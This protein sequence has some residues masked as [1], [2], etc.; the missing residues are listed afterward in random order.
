MSI[1]WF[2]VLGAGLIP[3]ILGFVWYH[4]KVFG[5]A[6]MKEASVSM[7]N[8]KQ[9]NM[10]LIFG[11]TLLFGIFLSMAMLTITIHQMHMMST[12]MNVPG[13]GKEGTEVNNYYMD[14]LAK[15][16]KEFRTFKH[17]ALHGLIGGIFIVLPIVAVNA[18]FEQK[19]A[20][21]ILINTG[22]WTACM[23]LMGGIVCQWS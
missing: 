13:F 6:W 3:L 10:S 11:L 18:M 15:Y 14:F 1:N 20:K 21:Y 7:D 17:G 12:L 23:I 16:G 22:F 9:M 19:K 4:P 5:S 8:A 2:V